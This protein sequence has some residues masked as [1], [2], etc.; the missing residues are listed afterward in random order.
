M[1][2]AAV[3]S[4]V[5]GYLQYGFRLVVYSVIGAGVAVLSSSAYMSNPVYGV[6]FGLAAAIAQIVF[7]A[8]W[9]RFEIKVDPHAF[10]F[11]GQGFLGIF[12]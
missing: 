1:S 4:T 5:L 9:D 7:V 12:F 6:V 8:V 3:L 11:V 10:V 2:S